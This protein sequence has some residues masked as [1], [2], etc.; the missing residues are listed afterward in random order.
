MSLD[1]G[2]VFKCDSR[3]KEAFFG[4]DGLFDGIN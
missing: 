2:C 1:D 4:S 3:D